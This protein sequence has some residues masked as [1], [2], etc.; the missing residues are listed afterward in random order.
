V[1]KGDLLR[2]LSIRIQHA[3][4]LVVHS[5]GHSRVSSH[6]DQRRQQVTQPGDY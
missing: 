6:E 2:L 5:D 3:K 1:K 4:Q